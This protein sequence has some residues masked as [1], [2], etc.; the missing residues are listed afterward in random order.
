MCPFE[1]RFC[2]KSAVFWAQAGVDRL[3]LSAGWGGISG[4]T[5]AS[6]DTAGSG[7]QILGTRKWTNLGM[8]FIRL[9]KN[10]RAMARPRWRR[11][12]H[13]RRWRPASVPLACL[14]LLVSGM[15]ERRLEPVNWRPILDAQL[16]YL[17]SLHRAFMGERTGSDGLH[18]EK[19]TVAEAPPSGPRAEAPFDS[20]SEEGATGS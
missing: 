5:I 11:M 10:E 4:P 18:G 19:P 14:M 20:C 12:A 8:G 13:S 7:D 15:H 16:R 1:G 3:R 2:L 6:G 17:D 9:F